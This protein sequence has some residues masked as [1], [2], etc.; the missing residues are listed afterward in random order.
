M[1]LEAQNPKYV[2]VNDEKLIAVMSKAWEPKYACVGK[3][4]NQ[5]MLEQLCDMWFAEVIVV[6]SR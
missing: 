6:I 4:W 3:H 1:I 2:Y 5:T